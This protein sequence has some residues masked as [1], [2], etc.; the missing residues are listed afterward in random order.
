MPD[1]YKAY[2]ERIIEMMKEEY[3][4]LAS[5]SHDIQC[6]KE[7]LPAWDAVGKKLVSCIDTWLKRISKEVIRACEKK[8]SIYSA[9]MNDF[10]EAGDKY[11]ADICRRCKEK[12]ERYA[13][14]LKD[15]LGREGEKDA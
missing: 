8:I 15:R 2:R 6:N 11:R 7:A 1:S 3:V 12:N 10:T 4:S 14:V 9:Y 5:V 13:S